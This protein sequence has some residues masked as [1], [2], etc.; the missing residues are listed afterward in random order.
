MI[1]L[2]VCESSSRILEPLRETLHQFAKPRA[3][4]P[5][6]LLDVWSVR[7]N[8]KDF[9]LVKLERLESAEKQALKLDSGPR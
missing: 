2:L 3:P 5:V 9:W 1:R 8:P 4:T 7:R 6:K